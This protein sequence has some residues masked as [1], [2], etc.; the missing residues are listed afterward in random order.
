MTLNKLQAYDSISSLNIS[1]QKLLEGGL[2]ANHPE[3]CLAH[4]FMKPHL[5]SR[6]NF[7]RYQHTLATVTVDRSFAK[8]GKSRDAKATVLGE[9]RM[10]KR[11]CKDR[12]DR[13]PRWRSPG[14]S[15]CGHNANRS[16]DGDLTDT[17]P[18]E[19]EN[20]RHPSPECR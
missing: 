10:G 1:V 5:D 18:G 8:N 16:L 6:S 12:E 19:A 3:K 15:T 4:H 14:R 20:D 2:N 17:T 7:N 13:R 9:G 11:T